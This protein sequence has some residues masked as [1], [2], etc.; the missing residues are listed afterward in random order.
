MTKTNTISKYATS[1]YQF[2]CTSLL[3]GLLMA[4]A[5]CGVTATADTSSF[6]KR[7]HLHQAWGTGVEHTDFQLTGGETKWQSQP[8]QCNGQTYYYQIE[9]KGG[10]GKSVFVRIG[11]AEALTSDRFVAR[12]T[13][14]SMGETAVKVW[15]PDCPEITIDGDSRSGIDFVLLP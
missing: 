7:L 12:F 9:L 15:G 10:S 11:T 3:A 13:V 14:D 4:L 2:R 6:P 8:F 1:R 5:V